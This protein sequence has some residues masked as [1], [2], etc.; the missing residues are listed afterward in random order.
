ML[1]LAAAMAAFTVATHDF[2]VSSMN[3]RINNELTH[4]VAE[5]KA[6]AARQGAVG[7][8]EA[9]DDSRSRAQ[10][11]RATVLSVLQARV[12]SA[13]LER[14]T[15]LLGIV[16]GKIA[17]TSRSFNA[18]RGPSVAVLARWAALSRPAAGTVRMAGG[19]ATYRAI[20]V[21]IRGKPARGVF[22]AA[23]LTSQGQT[24]I[25]NVTRLQI[26]VGAIALLVGALLAWLVAGRVLRP[27]RATTELAR[28][29]TESDLSA[30]IPGRGRDE[31]SALA[32]TFNRMLDRLEA[33]MITQHRFLAD[34]G[35]EL[36]TPITV[37]QGNLDT[38]TAHTDED[39]ET[40]AIV[41]DEISR[42]NRLVDELLLLAG[43][44]R[45]D[46]LRPEP[47]DLAQL[48]RS[49]L[50]KA[51]GLADRPW[52]LTSAAED[53]AVLDPQ[54]ITQAVMQLAA[55]AV[56]H[57]PAG[58]P[59]EL[60]SQIRNG[61]VT[62]TVSDHGPG[63]PAAARDQVFGRFARL[64]PRRTEGTGLGLAIVAAICAAH[65]GSVRV[66]SRDDAGRGAAFCLVIPYRAAP[67]AAAGAD[68]PR[69]PAS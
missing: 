14:D 31:V 45:P 24:S 56:A 54:R 44:E 68:I 18:A 26:E 11:R 59:V 1:L 27:V 63:I 5:F 33:A 53:I 28:R 49:L 51:R 13:V 3:T 58:S 67:A 35:H 37:I 43:S 21:Q 60:S 61:L 50:A 55:N 25:D 7:S 15:V 4:E 47:T 22:V 12:S 17:T 19:A 10:R 65:G 6:L 52:I 41:A 34:A 57:T 30:R 64:D 36:R 29:I 40:L 23:V 48:T 32:V 2:L 20:P 16:G 66:D 39:A 38:M 42:M 69:P 62:F 46:F 8:P 9:G